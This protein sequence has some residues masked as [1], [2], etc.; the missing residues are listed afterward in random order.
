MYRRQE[1]YDLIYRTLRGL[2]EVKPAVKPA[3][4][5]TGPARW[6]GRMLRLDV[7]AEKTPDHPAVMYM[8]NRG[9]DPAELGRDYGFMFCDE[10]CEPKYR[11]VLGRII[12]PVWKGQELWSWL[13]RY[14]GPE[15]E[16]GKK[17]I[18][19]Y[20]NMPGRSLASVGYNLDRV[21]CYSTVVITE[22]VLDAVRTGP[23]ATCLFTK[24]VN[25]TLRKKILRGLQQYKNPVIVIMLDPEQSEKEKARGAV[26][27]IEKAA[28]AFRGYDVRVVTVYLP[29]GTDPG[30]LPRKEI[31]KQIRRAAKEQGV[32]LDFT[33]RKNYEPRVTEEEENLRSGTEVRSFLDEEEGGSAEETGPAGHL[34]GPESAGDGHVPDDP[35]RRKRPVRRFVSVEKT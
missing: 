12:I 5:I 9:F 6:P 31:M 11:P 34:A 27:H 15:E 21:L 28:D 18:R 23:F 16:T 33:E 1:L 19:K 13:G 24:T 35:P 29:E 7:L 25:Q 14:I 10:V 32:R 17:R 4:K 30:S 3:E 2:S 20:Y 8:A 26:H 22:G